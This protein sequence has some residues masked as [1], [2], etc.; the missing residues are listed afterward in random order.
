MPLIIIL[1]F[2]G[3]SKPE[4]SLENPDFKINLKH[5]QISYLQKVEPADPFSVENINKALRNLKNNGSSVPFDR[6]EP[7]HVYLRFVPENESQLELLKNDTTLIL[8]DFPLDSE[9]NE[10]ESVQEEVNTDPG[11]SSSIYRCADRAGVASC[12]LSDTL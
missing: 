5:E 1:L 11:I 9:I 10:G 6:I 3:C 12:E 4:E 8:Y 2:P 7:N